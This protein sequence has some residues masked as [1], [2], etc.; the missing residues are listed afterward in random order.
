MFDKLTQSDLD[1]MQEEIDHRIQV[2]RPQALEDLK[3]A[4]S[5]GDLSE[6]FEYYAAKRFKNQNESRIRYLQRM[7]RTAEVIPEDSASD[8]VGIDNTVEVEF[9]EDGT[10]EEYKIVTTVR[11]NSL[12]GLIT[13]ESPL[14]KALLGKKVGDIV[15]VRV[16][17]QVSYEVKIVRLEKTTGEGDTIRSF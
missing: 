15:E 7:I 14:G 2:V 11:A 8:E 9:L 3:E 5:H 4:K 12:N 17:D 16:N 6:N 1:K 10:R 13:N